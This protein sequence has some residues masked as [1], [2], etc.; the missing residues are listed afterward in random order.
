L[1][2]C[3]KW[4]N[5]LVIIIKIIAW[6]F[7]IV[8][9][10]VADLWGRALGGF[11][12]F[13]LPNKLSLSRQALRLSF[14]DWPETEIKKVSRGVFRTQGIFLS[15]MF[16]LIGRARENPVDMIDCDPA[17]FEELKILHGKSTGVLVLTA[18]FNNYELLMTWAARYFPMSIVAKRI[19]PQSLDH[20]INHIRQ[21]NKINVL[22]ARWSYRAIFKALGKGDCLGFVMD[23]NMKHME[24]VFVTFFGRPACTTPGLAMLSAHSKSPVLPAFL[25]RKGNRHVLR[26]FPVIQPPPDREA[27]TLQDFTQLYSNVIEQVIREQPEAW[28]WMHKR[29]KTQPKSGSRITRSDGSEYYV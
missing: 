3:G 18:H 19:H 28:I 13:V 9:R 29:W 10:R 16:R 25:I 5:C 1:D 24:G 26:T 21:E 8:P 6:F 2:F 12:S 7:S 27:K 17:L 4:N 14:P 23:Q 15:E 11:L 22:P 20:F